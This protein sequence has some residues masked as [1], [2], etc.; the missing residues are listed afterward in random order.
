M[1]LFDFLPFQRSQPAQLH[2]QDRLRL[3]FGQ[4]EA[5][6]QPFARGVGIRRLADGVDDLVQVRQ[7]HQQPFQNVRPLARLV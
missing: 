5:G 1:F 7:R 2:I 3:D 6:D 4:A